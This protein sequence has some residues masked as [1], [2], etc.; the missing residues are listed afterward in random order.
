[1]TSRNELPVFKQVA[2]RV[3]DYPYG[4]TRAQIA[5]DFHVTKSTA[6]EHLEKCVERHM[7]VKYYAWQNGRSR[8]WIYQDPDTAPAG[9]W[10]VGELPE[11]LPEDPPAPE[12]HIGSFVRRLDGNGAE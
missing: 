12:H 1:M 4:A 9:A 8:G 6:K 5:D 10:D 2:L 11:D 7:L 3:K